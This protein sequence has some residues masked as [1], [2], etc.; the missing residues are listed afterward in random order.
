M[1]TVIIAPHPD[2]E[3]IGCGCTILKKLDNGE[4]IKVL[5]ISSLS[6]IPN[7]KIKERAIV[8]QSLA[9]HY[10]YECKLLGETELNINKEKFLSLLDK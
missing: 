8:S 1:T 5:L 4:N 6:K 9:K 10:N 2:D 3:W 7:S